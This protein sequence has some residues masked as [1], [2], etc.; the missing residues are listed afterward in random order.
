[1]CEIA[2]SLHGALNSLIPA[3]VRDAA[4]TTNTLVDL[5]AES[6]SSKQS[7]SLETI[8]T[9]YAHLQANLQR[10]SNPSGT[11]DDLQGLGEPKFHVNGSAFTDSW[12]RPQRDGPALR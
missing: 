1:M 7:S 6:P 3:G 11:L 12:G 2:K 5:Y 10:T 8:L 9:A 4:I